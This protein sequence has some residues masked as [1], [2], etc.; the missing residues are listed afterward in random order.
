MRIVAWLPLLL[1]C[2]GGLVASAVWAG[3]NEN[4][5]RLEALPRAQRQRLAE[6]LARFDRLGAAER[7]ALQRLDEQLA[8]QPAEERR[9]YLE[10]MRRYHLWVQGLGAGQRQELQAVPPE[11]RLEIIRRIR[12]AQRQAQDPRLEAIWNRSPAFHPSS[13][14]EVAHLIKVWLALDPRERAEV[15][16]LEAPERVQRLARLGQQHGIT[17]GLPIP[18]ELQELRE[19]V[20]RGLPGRDGAL[21]RKDLDDLRHVLGEAAPAPQGPLAAKK[22]QARNNLLRHL[23]SVYFRKHEPEPVVP[24]HLERFEAALPSWLDEQIDPL[25][26]D[27]ARRRLTLLYR[28]VFPPPEEMPVS[29]SP[30]PAA[31][32]SPDP[33]APDPHSPASGATPF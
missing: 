7:R 2:P 10:L 13:L 23:E 32:P 31:V 3:E 16:A 5:Q 12:A 14:F 24:P 21:S 20:E 17:R 29:P 33:R 28:L 8:A 15:D 4:R 11:Q 6:N 25:P 26:P 27:A 18:P 30:V 9:R 19:Q 1:L 22:A